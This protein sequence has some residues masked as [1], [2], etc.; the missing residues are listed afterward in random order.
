MEPKER[1]AQL[2]AVPR[3]RKLWLILLVTQTVNAL[4]ALYSIVAYLLF[5]RTTTDPA[6][7]TTTVVTIS[8][9]A[10]ILYTLLSM[11]L[12]WSVFLVARWVGVLA[13]VS[14]GFALLTFNV[15]GFILSFVL[16]LGYRKLQKPEAQS[17]TTPPTAS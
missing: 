16:V 6:A 12:T 11:V 10:L 14:V 15:I 2:Q 1:R 5:L 8:L 13:W 3:Q 4:F 7:V 9:A 17:Q